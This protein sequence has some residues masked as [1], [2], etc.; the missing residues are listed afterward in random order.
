MWRIPRGLK[1]ICIQ[2]AGGFVPK[3]AVKHEAINWSKHDAS[4]QSLYRLVD[5]AKLSESRR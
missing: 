2:G 3:E 4:F 5:S 1:A